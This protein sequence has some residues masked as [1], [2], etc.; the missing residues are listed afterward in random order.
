MTVRNAPWCNI[1]A[2][3]ALAV[4]LLS[5]LDHLDQ[6]GCYPFG[7][8]F[9][10]GDRLQVSVSGELCKF[11]FLCFAHKRSNTLSIDYRLMS[12]TTQRL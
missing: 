7:G 6:G 3:H 4:S 5:G 9:V 10:D 1:C 8:Q 11:N 12:P 2:S